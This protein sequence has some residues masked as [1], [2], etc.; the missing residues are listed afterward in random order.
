MRD[1]L[2]ERRGARR[3]R[4]TPAARP[5][6][7]RSGYS[8]SVRSGHREEF[9]PLR[10]LDA[11][12]GNLPAQ[13]SSFIG[14]QARSHTGRHSTGDIARGDRHRRG[15]CRQ[16]PL[17]NSGCRRVLPRYPRR[18]LAGRLGAGRDPDGV[19]QRW[20]RIPTDQRRREASRGLA[21]RDARSTSQLLLVLDNC[22]HLLGPW[23][24]RLVTRI[25]REC[26]GVVVLATSREGM[27][28]DGEQLI[29]LPP[30]AVGEPERRH[31]SL[32]Q[33]RRRQAVRRTGAPGQG[34][35][36]LDTPTMPVPSWRSASARR[37]PA[38][39]RVGRG[40]G[41]RDEPDRACRAARSPISRAGGRATGRRRA[42]RDAAGGHRLVI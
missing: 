10:S 33:H 30:M 16:D 11:F 26:P 35:L 20:H 14:R 27:A 6:A 38:G 5:R 41:H 34:G 39:H 2:P 28:I 17:G 24:A 32:L 15:R 29:A 4:R 12:P 42:P 1:Q 19:V 21:P 13:V 23:P 3:S 36:R 8:S 31:R 9:P 7:S 40:P 22:E 25:E 37:R 18:R